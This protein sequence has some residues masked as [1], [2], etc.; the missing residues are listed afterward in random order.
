[1]EKKLTPFVIDLPKEWEDETVYMF[2]G[3]L[4]GGVQHYLRLIIDHHPGKVSLE[5]YAADRTAA[6]KD[7]L[8]SIE[9]LKEEARELPNGRQIFEFVYKWIPSDDKIIFQKQVY[10]ILDGIGYTFSCEFTKQTLKTIGVQVDGL[11]NSFEPL[12]LS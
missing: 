2:R 3:P 11:I 8:G 4:D 10:M 6:I 7:N 5:D 9:V 12:D 1:M